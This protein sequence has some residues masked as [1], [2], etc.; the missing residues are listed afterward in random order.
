M[1]NLLKRELAPVTDEAWEQIDRTAVQILKSNLTARSL[2]DFNG[3]HGWAYGA[4]NLGQLDIP[5]EHAGPEGIPWGVRRVQPLIEVR[6]PIVLD[7]A[8]LDNASRGNPNIELDPLK[9][10]SRKLAHF[11]ERVIYNGFD[12]GCIKGL[13]PSLGLP[14]IQTSANGEAY[15]QAVTDAVEA[16][17]G[18]GVDGP[19]ALVLGPRAFHELMRVVS[20][21]YPPYRIIQELLK[22]GEILWSPVLTG[23]LVL[24]K[25]GGDFELTIG[26]D[27]SIGYANHDRMQVELF[28]TESLTFRVLEPMAAIEIRLEG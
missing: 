13:I 21:G 10:A 19:Y 7:Q 17:I 5:H 8:E 23:A 16:L 27:A 15:P 3:P 25:R 24:S 26:Q 1:V 9:E 6:I 18:A 20:S 4:I 28:L 2:V 14:A 11:E 12:S 22:G